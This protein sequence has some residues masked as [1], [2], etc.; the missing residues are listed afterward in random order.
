MTS[1]E[2]TTWW[3]CIVVSALGCVGGIFAGAVLFILILRLLPQF[4]PAAIPFVIVGYVSSMFFGLLTGYVVAFSIWLA[5]VRKTM[6][7]SELLSLMGD[8]RIQRPACARLNRRW[9]AWLL[10]LYRLDDTS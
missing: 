7:A 1:K 6:S 8:G 9:V 4:D 3:T 5:L 10:R 2:Q